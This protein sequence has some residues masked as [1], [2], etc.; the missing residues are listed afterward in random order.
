MSRYNLSQ[1]TAGVGT[2]C[3]FLINTYIS[4][5]EVEHIEEVVV[6]AGEIEG[7]SKPEEELE[8]SFLVFHIRV[9]TSGC[10]IWTPDV[11]YS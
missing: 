10:S 7:F 9:H 11:L 6:S 8:V 1:I 5:G 3:D 2:L 4:P